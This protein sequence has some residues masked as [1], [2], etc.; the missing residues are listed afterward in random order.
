MCRCIE[1]GWMRPMAT[2]EDGKVGGSGKGDRYFTLI[3]HG[4]VWVLQ[5]Q[6]DSIYS[7]AFVKYFYFKDLLGSIR[8]DRI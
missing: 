5:G 7:R 8:F 3:F 1:G 4:H 6:H 2:G